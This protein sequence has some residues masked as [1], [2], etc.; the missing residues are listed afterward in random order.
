MGETNGSEQ[1]RG[2][3]NTYPRRGFDSRRGNRRGYD[4]G[5]GRDGGGLRNRGTDSITDQR[6]SEDTE[7]RPVGSERE[8]SL[9]SRDGILRRENQGNET[10]RQPAATGDVRAETRYENSHE[11]QSDRRGGS[12]RNN[13]TRPGGRLRG[14][15][16]RSNEQ[17][18]SSESDSSQQS[19]FPNAGQNKPPGT[20]RGMDLERLKDIKERINIPQLVQELEV[21][22]TTGKIECMICYD[23]VGRNAPVWS[24][25]SCYS[26]FHMPCVRK[27]ARAPTSSDISVSATGNGEANWRCPGCQAVQMST[28]NELQYYCFCGQ[29][30]EPALDYYITPHSCGGPCRKPLDKSK[31]GY[32]KHICTLQCHPGPCPPCTA[33]APP[34]PCPCGKSTTSRKCAEQG[35]ES[36]SC[37]EP[38]GRRLSC[39]RHECAQICH[40][41]ACEPCSILFDAK[42]F[43][44]RREESLQCWQVEPP[45]EIDL[46]LGVFSCE[47]ECPKMLPCG[48]H[49]CGNKCHPGSCGECE[50]S[51]SVIRTC[52]CGKKKLAELQEAG[53]ERRSCVDPIPTCEQTCGKLLTCEKH[54]CKSLCHIGPCPDCDVPVEQKCQCGGSTR[55]AACHLTRRAGLK[56]D[57]VE[58]DDG[59]LFLCDR[60]CGKM[61]SCGRHR[62]NDR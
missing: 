13:D 55:Q 21:K 14:N 30:R 26:I 53:S 4:S 54:P 8:P 12:R 42:C 29:V 31:S 7:S 43:C 5:R 41:G 15:W 22:L 2:D 56:G 32:C 33:L 50:L 44:G 35:K 10:Q 18:P 40:E 17:Q 27:W 61:R 9:P 3:S 46:G 49:M 39:G 20:G 19:K 47:M 57:D 23:N 62:C 51:P 59:G 6:R 58:G 24:C 60:K 34:Q 37:G 52:P 16:R 11:N 45:G 1:L 28:A 48:N 25:A 38:C 36:R